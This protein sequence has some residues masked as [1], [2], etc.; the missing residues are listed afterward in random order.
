MVE[1][2]HEGCSGLQWTAACCHGFLGGTAPAAQARCRMRQSLSGIHLLPVF[3]HAVL[4]PVQ[5][6]CI[7]SSIV[8]GSKLSTDHLRCHQT[9]WQ[10]R[11]SGVRSPATVLADRAQ[12][13]TAG[14][15]EGFQRTWHVEQG[16]ISALAFF[17]METSIHYRI[18]CR[19]GVQSRWNVCL[20][21]HRLDPQTTQAHNRSCTDIDQNGGQLGV[22]VTN[23]SCR[24]LFEAG[25]VRR[26]R[27]NQLA[28]LSTCMCGLTALQDSSCASPYHKVRDANILKAVL[29]YVT[30]SILARIDAAYLDSRRSLD[31]KLSRRRLSRLST[32]NDS[33]MAVSRPTPHASCLHTRTMISSPPELQKHCYGYCLIGVITTSLNHAVRTGAWESR[34]PA[35]QLPIIT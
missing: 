4:Y 28:L 23:S 20:G 1:S 15:L 24:R 22:R 17:R 27:R 6:D 21:L 13:I 29:V 12:R 18:R 2:C 26:L 33:R 5:I 32:E 35:E 7:A 9:V 31:C 8:R 30:C 34:T 10:R 14:L 3:C 11:E 16:D 19:T 25:L